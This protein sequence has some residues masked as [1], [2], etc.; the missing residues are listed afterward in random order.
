M[1]AHVVLAQE[2]FSVD[3]LSLFDSGFHKKKY[4]LMHLF[5]NNT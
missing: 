5:W 3:F 1:D 4:L 2:P